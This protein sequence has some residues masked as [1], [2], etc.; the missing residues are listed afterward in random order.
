VSF[1][2]L[3]EVLPREGA[4]ALIQKYAGAFREARDAARS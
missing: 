2:T 3:A 4:K 1:R